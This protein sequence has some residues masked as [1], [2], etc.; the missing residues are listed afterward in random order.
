MVELYNKH[1][2]KQYI[3]FSNRNGY[4]YIYGLSLSS[5]KGIE[6]IYL[7]FEVSVWTIRYKK[8]VYVRDDTAGGS[9]RRLCIKLTINM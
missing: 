4:K 5:S 6:K 8:D 2:F 7:V 9:G 3:L 1:Y